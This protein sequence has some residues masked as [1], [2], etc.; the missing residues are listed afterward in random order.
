MQKEG[1]KH[2]AKNRT[3]HAT[4]A[5]APPPSG[6]GA[7]SAVLAVQL[8][9][10]SAVTG[11]AR[12]RLAALFAAC[13]LTLSPACAGFYPLHCIAILCMLLHALTIS[14]VCKCLCYSRCTCVSHHT[15]LINICS[16]IPSKQCCS[17]WNMPHASKTY[18]SLC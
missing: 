7:C 15:A 8:D 3:M 1:V 5:P 10:S 17:C 12:F 13:R 16:G 2:A 14:K 11:R 6:A 18:D 4:G 9:T